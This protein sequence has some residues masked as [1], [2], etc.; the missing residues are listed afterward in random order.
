[1]TERACGPIYLGSLLE[2]FSTPASFIIERLIH[3]TASLCDSHTEH[4]YKLPLWLIMTTDTRDIAYPA[5]LPRPRRENAPIERTQN[6]EMVLYARGLRQ[7]GQQ[8]P[9]KLS[10]RTILGMCPIQPC[11]LM[12]S[13]AANPQPRW[14]NW[15]QTLGSPIGQTCL[16]TGGGGGWCWRSWKLDP[17]P[18]GSD[19]KSRA[20]RSHRPQGQFRH[21][22]ST[23]ASP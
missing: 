16:L 9:N 22:G 15:T 6:C 19:R 8:W 5:L 11:L 7:T 14:C 20:I 3:G 2:L 23:A 12:A 17:T 21:T 4:L 13:R 10:P 1:M 18:Q